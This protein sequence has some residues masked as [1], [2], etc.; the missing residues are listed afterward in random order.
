VA[1]LGEGPGGPALPPSLFW[2]KK[3]AEGRK[4]IRA[5]K[6]YWAHH[7]S[8]RSGP[9]TA[10]IDLCTCSIHGSYPFFQKKIS[11]TFPELL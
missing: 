10:A 4:A 11:R 3:I 2:V 6:K 1:D 5:G 9:A 8:S 7:L